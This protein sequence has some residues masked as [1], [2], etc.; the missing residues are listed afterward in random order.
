MNKLVVTHTCGHEESHSTLAGSERR[1][2]WIAKKRAEKPCSVCSRVAWQADVDTTNAYYAELAAEHNLPALAGTDR[3]LPW[4]TGLRGELLDQVDANAPKL[5]AMCT[6]H[7][8]PYEPLGREVVREI[9][10]MHTDAGWWIEHRRQLPTVLIKEH[11]R[12]LKLAGPAGDTAK[13]L[14][15]LLDTVR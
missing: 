11:R 8:R 13:S 4:A 6:S 2:A 9:V 10:S 1:R 5:A 12:G 14:L 7:G 15:L 3:Q